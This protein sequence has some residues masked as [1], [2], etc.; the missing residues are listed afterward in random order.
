MI[1]TEIRRAELKK[2]DFDSSAISANKRINILK[3][4]SQ[5]YNKSKFQAF[6]PQIKKTKK[7]EPKND[8]LSI[9]TSEDEN[10]NR[11]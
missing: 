1:K 5:S 9:T 2:D 11:S 6:N 7:E 4:I 3:Q 10:E 8:I